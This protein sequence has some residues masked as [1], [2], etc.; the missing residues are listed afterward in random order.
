VITVQFFLP[1]WL[2]TREPWYK[3]Y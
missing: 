3:S 1:I 2:L